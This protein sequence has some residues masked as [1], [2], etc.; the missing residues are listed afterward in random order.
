MRY[1]QPYGTPDDSPYVNGNP[2]QGVQGSIPPAPAF[3]QPQREIV[4]V[5]QKSGFNPLDADLLQLAKGIRSQRLNYAVDTSPVAN[6]INVTFDPPFNNQNPYTPG[7][8]LHVR[9]R[10]FN[11]GGQVQI[12]AGAG[13]YP[14]RRQQGVDLQPGDLPAQGIATLVF[15]GSAFQLSNFGG[16]TGGGGDVTV[17]TVNIPY[18][19][20]QSPLTGT[21]LAPFDPP[22]QR[23]PTAGDIVAVQIANTAPG[24]TVMTVALQGGVED[25]KP[26]FPNGGGDMLQGDMAAGDVV[27]FF[28]DGVAWR[29]TPSPEITASVT[30]TVGTT[31]PGQQ[32][33]TIAAAMDAL[34]RKII[35]ANG[36]VTLLMA[37]EIFTGPISIAHPSGDRL[38]IQGTMAYAGANPSLDNFQVTGASPILRA[39]DAAVNLA[40]MSARYGTKITVAVTDGQSGR[41]VGIENLGSGSVTFSDLLIYSIAGVPP[42]VGG[43]PF[44]WQYGAYAPAGFSITLNNV[45]V[46]GCQVGFLLIGGT[47]A[48]NAFASGCWA[49]FSNAGVLSAAFC[50]AYGSQ[51]HGFYSTF[52]GIS[53]E[54]CRARG[55][56][57]N[58]FMANNSGAMDLWYI[59]SDTNNGDGGSHDL[60]ANAGS[61]VVVYE[62]STYN[63]WSPPGATALGKPNGTVG[64]VNSFV[65]STAGNRP[66]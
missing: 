14:V 58:G 51:T 29:F 40:N 42:A 2:A 31:T 61:S 20:D 24:P 49:G 18:V 30:Y 1:Q 8:V 17:V 47:I 59:W 48:R 25:T 52:G 50:G 7:L 22:L 3:E 19:V 6:Q 11:T 38:R 33:P 10:N 5:I 15:D 4:N 46:C 56:G 55:N 26:C 36:Y 65:L 41:D 43:T 21:I 45:C 9:V 53:V 64:N 16:A 62:P 44:Y 34:K 39:N 13:N 60:V 57:Y 54:W 63:T 66:A 12:Q 32:Y 28:F 27:Q 35:G 23:A 37:P